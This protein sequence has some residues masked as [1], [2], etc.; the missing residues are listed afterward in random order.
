MSRNKLRRMLALGL[1]LTALSAVARA[2]DLIDDTL[3]VPESAN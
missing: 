1:A 3:L 2:D